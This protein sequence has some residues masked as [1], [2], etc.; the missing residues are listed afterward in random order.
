LTNPLNLNMVNW[1]LT[2]VHRRAERT[3]RDL[4]WRR[5]NPRD[6]AARWTMVA[7]ELLTCCSWTPVTIRL[8]WPKERSRY[9]ACSI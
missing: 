4:A 8:G 6:A 5:Q 1:V 2:L 9:P 7:T 3:L